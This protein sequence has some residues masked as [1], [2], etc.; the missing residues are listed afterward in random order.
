MSTETREILE[1]LERGEIDSQ[2]AI[3]MMK[4]EKSSRSG[5]PG[6]G[7]TS[8]PSENEN[9]YLRVDVHRLHDDRQQVHVRVPLRIVELGLSLGS[10]YAPE[11]QDID[12][13][14]IVD[15]LHEMGEGT[16]IEVEDLDDNQH[17]MVW[18]EKA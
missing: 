7:E 8:T 5:R 10:R 1:Q 9:H 11:L 13:K 3:L 17:V 18:I 14:Q 15:E 12:L 4:G 2:E 16:I 6:T